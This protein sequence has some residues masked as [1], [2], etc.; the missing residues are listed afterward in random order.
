MKLVIPQSFWVFRD[1]IF[2]MLLIELLCYVEFELAFLRILLINQLL[3]LRGSLFSIKLFYLSSTS[4]IL[5]IFIVVYWRHFDLLYLLRFAFLNYLVFI[6]LILILAT[7]WLWL[8]IKI[9]I[10]RVIFMVLEFWLLFL[11]L[12]FFLLVISSLHFLSEG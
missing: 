10:S 1:L 9:H 8:V 4:S 2:P 5:L 12:P 6:F 11:S 7:T 3:L